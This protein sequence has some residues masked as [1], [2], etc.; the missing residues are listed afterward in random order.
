MKRP[1]WKRLVRAQEENSR[2]GSA[3]YGK[4]KGNE[5]LD[6]QNEHIN[7]YNERKKNW[8]EWMMMWSQWR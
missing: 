8:K 3:S 2:T 6:E 1:T 7:R 4:R 5:S